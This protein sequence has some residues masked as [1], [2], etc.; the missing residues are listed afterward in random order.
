M[1]F[2]GLLFSLSVGMREKLPG[3]IRFLS[4]LLFCFLLLIILCL[5]ERRCSGELSVRADQMFNNPVKKFLPENPIFSGADPHAVKFKNTFW[6]YPTGGRST[7]FYAYYSTNLLNWERVGPVLDFKDVT[8]IEADGQKTHY[9]WAPCVLEWSGKFYFYYSV[10]PQNPTPSRIGVAVAG[11]PDGP[12][13]DS[14]RPLVVGDKDFEA[15]DPMVF[16]DPVTQDRYLYAG[17][18][19]GN[20][21]CVFALGQDMMSIV[22]EVKV[23][24]PPNFTEGVFI[25]VYKGKY[26]LSYSSGGWRD[27][28]YSVHYCISESPIGPW[29]YKGVI[30]R[31]D[32]MRKGPGHHSFL[33]DDESGRWLIFYHRW[34]G[35]EGEG[36]YQGTRKVCIEEVHYNNDGTIQPIKMTGGLK[37]K[38]PGK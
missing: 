33:Y 8:W 19:A 27:S 34:D 21:M 13:V 32:E 14:G 28:S 6:V 17:G 10:G 18:S 31:S 29:V 1:V 2:L 26:Y 4:S 36:P 30:L 3:L 5:D 22:K 24:T 16:I 15:I 38:Q 12:F 35:V 37:E 11:T 9:A 25:H 7:Q 20:K 23:D